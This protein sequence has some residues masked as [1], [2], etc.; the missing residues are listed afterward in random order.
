[1]IGKLTSRNIQQLNQIFSD[2]K[3]EFVEVVS[4][5]GNII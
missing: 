2:T 5:S 1:M 4:I 3:C